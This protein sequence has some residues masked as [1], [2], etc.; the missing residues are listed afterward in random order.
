MSNEDLLQRKDI[1]NILKSIENRNEKIYAIR[2]FCNERNH[3][4]ELGLLDNSC[5]KC[6]LHDYC[7]IDEIQTF[8]RLPDNILTFFCDIIG[9]YESTQEAPYK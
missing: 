2:D 6:P 5:T 8:V 4:E 3:K 9:S 7:S 1:Q